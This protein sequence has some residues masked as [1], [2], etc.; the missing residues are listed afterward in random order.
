MPGGTDAG[1]P[2]GELAGLGAGERR[3]IG[4]DPGGDIGWTTSRFAGLRNGWRGLFSCH[5]QSVGVPC[6]I[7]RSWK[8]QRRTPEQEPVMKLG[9]IGVGAV[10]AATAMA[11]ALRARTREI[12]LIDKDRARA[13]AVAT[14]MHYGVPLS[15][16]VT[17]A[18]GDYDDL[19]GAGLAII[20][21][22]INEKAGGATDRNDPAGRLRLL[23]T[24]V[25]VFEDIVPR[26]VEVAPDAVILVATNPPEPLVEVAR[27][28]AGHDRV[29]STSTYLDSLRF[30]VHLAERLGVSPA[31]VEANV[32]G[33]HGTSSV[34]LWS[35]A[36]IGGMP[37]TDLLAKHDIALEAFRRDVEQDVRYANIT[38][39]EGIG[40]SQYG[41]GMVAGRV[42]EVVLRDER[43]VFPVG[44]HNPR[45]GVT[46]S[47]PSV[48]GRAGVIEVLWP[49]MSD[50]ESK[51]LERSAETLRNVVRK[52]VATSG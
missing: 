36:R 9:I 6:R 35:S 44:S 22:G 21:A 1:M 5:P 32:V 12:V 30:R 10:G 47:L 24:N 34:F 13:K 19:A 15:P 43:A 37:I 41:I 17:I 7:L 18:D 51:A 25:R 38:I 23:D 2:A 40:A 11:V 14:D 48:V 39:I 31:C 8:P 27:H 16:I 20:T 26:L 49:D 52:F 50:D 4:Q 46:L 29:M 3:T 33:E 42:A 28:L 45:Y